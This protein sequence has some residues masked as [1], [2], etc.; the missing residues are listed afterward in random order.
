M[1]VWRDLSTEQ[2]LKSPQP[3]KQRE[4][5]FLSPCPARSAAGPQPFPPA[6]SLLGAFPSFLT[7]EPLLDLKMLKNS[8]K[9]CINVSEQGESPFP[10]KEAHNC[11]YPI[12]VL[13]LTTP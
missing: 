11:Q 6:V 5:V 8:K 2:A 10:A 1:A 12:V 4:H 9:R 3:Y 7:L 13:Q